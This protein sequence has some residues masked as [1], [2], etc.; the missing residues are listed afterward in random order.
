MVPRVSDFGIAGAS[1]RAARGTARY[2]APEQLGGGAVD[3][4]AD[5]HALGVMLAELLP[6]DPPADLADLVEQLCRNEADHRLSDPLTVHAALA[7]VADAES[8]RGGRS[9]ANWVA[10]GHRGVEQAGV[11]PTSA[12]RPAAIAPPTTTDRAH[13]P[14]FRD[15]FVG[16]ESEVVELREALQRSRGLVTVVGP[17]GVGESRLAI[18]AAAGVGQAHPGGVW[19]VG[20]TEARDASAIALDIARA[21][22]IQLASP[23]LAGPTLL[24]AVADNLAARRPLLLILDNLEQV[25]D[26]AATLL[27]A[28]LGRVDSLRVLAT[29]RMP[30]GVRG[31]RVVWLD[32]LALPAEGDLGA[33]ARLFEARAR[34]IDPDFR[35]TDTNRRDVAR[36]AELT[37][38][39]PLAIELAAA[40]V[41]VL[42]TTRLAQRLGDQLRLLTSRGGERPDRQR[43]LRA[44]LDWSWALLDRTERRALAQLSVFEGTFTLEAAEAILDLAGAD[45]PWVDDV[46]M[47]LVDKSLLRS[48]IPEHNASPRLAL[49]RSV[50]SYAADH[51]DDQ[52][53]QRLEQRHGRFFGALGDGEPAEVLDV[54]GG[55]EQRLVWAQALSD[56]V[57]A[58]RRALSRGDGELAACGARGV[59]ALTAIQGPF[60][61]GLELLA[62]ALELPS[63]RAHALRLDLGRALWRDGKLDEAGAHLDAVAEAAGEGS[64]RAAALA[65]RGG[66]H[67]AQ[68][69]LGP[70]RECLQRA[71]ALAESE[72]L[73]RLLGV[74]D[75][76]LMVLCVMEGDP[77][78][79]DRIG[80]RALALHRQAGDVRSEAR[81]SMNLGVLAIR[82]GDLDRAERYLAQ[83]VATHRRMGNRHGLAFATGNL[84]Q[85]LLDRGDLDGALEQANRSVN[86]YGEVGDSP[87]Q[88]RFENLRARIL[89]ARG[90][91]EEAQR[92]LARS[93]RLVQTADTDLLRAF[94]QVAEAWVAL[95]SGEGERAMA[96]VVEAE[97]FAADQ[98]EA[99]VIRGDIAACRRAVEEDTG[100]TR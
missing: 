84:A 15:S 26:D 52:E 12:T 42:G 14:R 57:A 80:Q 67:W 48:W 76:N 28:W 72:G 78:E 55:E 81:T 96:A 9:L 99:G 44:T 20:L 75:G 36:I 23:G 17:G 27:G 88:S 63:D 66:L 16:R 19:F 40:R 87:Y 29:S 18:Q 94:H 32:T 69:A 91:F 21:L 37:D 97:R 4:R 62:L 5:Y 7:A 92:A 64:V 98:P 3:H 58:T 31:E 43:T 49:L 45:T 41:R 93:R 68:G 8:L 25:V 74:I 71:R 100:Q 85:L 6:A 89:A 13:L 77:D 33:A 35:I 56:L 79:G 46:L 11:D 24:R 39:L 22:G 90:E 61:L 34:A 38:G 60:S 54:H 70:S 65:A 47:A 30:L 53:R 95:A 73:A 82:R 50:K 1:G 51:L 2:A 59:W 86:L 83:T 10:E